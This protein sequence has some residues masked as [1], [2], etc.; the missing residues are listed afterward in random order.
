MLRVIRLPALMIS[1]GFLLPV[2]LPTTLAAQTPAALAAAGGPESDLAAGFRDPPPAARP[3]AYWC[4]LNGNVS[5]EH[6]ARE[7]EEM[8]EKGIS[9]VYIF[10]VGA[11]D[12]NKVI[13]A[14]PPFMGPESVEAIARAVREATRIG[15]DV[16]LITS[17][18][19]N[20]GGS[21]VRP[22]HAAMGRYQ[23]EIV[24]EGPKRFSEA[25][26][27]PKVSKNTPLGADGRPIY[28]KDVA[29]LAMPQLKRLPGHEFLFEVTPPGEHTVDHVVL[30][31]DQSDDPERRGPKH[32]FA[33]EFS[34]SVSATGTDADDFQEVVHG[35]LEPIAGPQ[36]FDFQPTKA[37]YVK[38]VILSGH[39]PKA[40]RVQLGE[41]EMYSTDGANVVS[42]YHSE[43]SRTGATLLRY[44]SALGQENDTEWTAANVHDRAKTGPGGS[45]CSAGLPPTVIEDAD[46]VLDLTDRLDPSGRLVWDVPPGKWTIIRVICANTGQGLAIP[47]P[48]SHGLAIDH[49]GA[50]ATEMHFRTMLDRLRAELGPFENTA[51]KMT[52][53]CSYELRGAAWTPDFLEQFRNYR[54]YDM[55]PYLP[56]LSGA[57]VENRE[58]TERFRYDYRKTLGDLLVDA[59]YKRA[60]EISNEYGLKLCAEA[61]G[62]GPPLH[63]VPVDALKAQGALDIPRGEFWNAHNVWVVKETACAAHIY[64]KPIV[65]MEAFTS[66]RHW[67]DGPFELK[68][69]GDRAMC[70]GTNHF[71]FHTGAHNPPEAGKPGWVYHA[72]THIYPNLAW[73]PKAGPF[74][75]YLARCS[76][77]LQ[78]GLFVA[79]VCYYYGDQGFNFVPPKHVDPSL[80]PGYDYD[81]TNAEVVLT[82]MDVAEGRIVLPDG[83]SYELLVLPD[84][85]DMDWDVLQKLEKLVAAGATVVG[86]KPVRSNGLTEYPRR[87]ERVRALADKLWGPCDGKEVLEH[88]YGQGKIVWGRSLREILRARGIGP[89]FQFASRSD[90]TELDYIHRRTETADVYFV[91]NKNPRW[92]E[93]DCTFRV[94]GK[95]PELWMPDTGEV[96]RQPVFDAVEGGMRVPLRLPPLGS[97]FVVFRHDVAK[98]HVVSLDKDNRRVFPVSP[99][100]VGELASAEVLAEDGQRFDLLASEPGTYTLETAQGRK[101]RVQV[102]ALPL[103]HQIT[104]PWQVRFP[105]GWGAPASATFDK[106]ISWTDHPDDGIKHFS[107]I[108]R[109][110]KQFELPAG[111]LTSDHQL[112]LDLGRVRFV[113][114]VWVND[115]HLGILWKPPFRVDVTEAIKPGNNHLVVEVANTWSNRLTGD[116]RSPDGKRFT[117]TNVTHALTWEVPWK[118]APLHESGLLGPVRLFCVKRI[119]LDLEQ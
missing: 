106:L 118:D 55:T 50:K 112:T 114:D 66:W 84:R 15:I 95:A 13:P 37:R 70:G 35:T 99:G 108:A 82:R 27:F 28:Y 12:P 39:D 104:G 48:N 2:D 54:G 94:T 42:L 76:Y 49:F 96:R 17:S 52:Y 59:F 24:V 10:D 103:P 107:G 22:Q 68:P 75:D 57:V 7:L 100:D 93:V 6:F 101:A 1:V 115:K 19:W 40:D 34:V 71:T 46:S 30:Y 23:S 14:G 25:L 33:K 63:N 47:S 80:G 74:I 113:A 91:A 90:Q 44:T 29:V 92:E 87:D 67:Q 60:R 3:A 26:P 116:A 16:G 72:G 38:L 105:E 89:D 73:W 83:M 8:K 61:G 9:A 119:E 64:G 81:V 109:Y 45:W 86:P 51:L 110:E 88:S 31:N 18:S 41:F 85:D 43:G 62:P 5:P 36:R 111:L 69:L 102:Q 97:V 20:A 21:W 117:N 79:D 11:R 32:S 4:W 53:V 58:I 98:D 77:L 78:Q 65:D 56:V